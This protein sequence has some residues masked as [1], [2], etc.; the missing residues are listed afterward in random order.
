MKCRVE[1]DSQTNKIL[2]V[3]DLQG[4]P[5]MIYKQLTQ[6]Y[7]PERALK[8]Y[9]LGFTNEYKEF[10]SGLNNY[11]T[12][13]LSSVSNYLEPDIESLRKF[14]K[15]NKLDKPSIPST[16]IETFMNNLSKI[17]SNEVIEEVR[18]DLENKF[19]RPLTSF[20]AMENISQVFGEM[21]LPIDGKAIPV[22]KLIGNI[23]NNPNT[24]KFHK[25]IINYTLDKLN[26][27]SK[28][29]IK[30]VSDLPINE[31]TQAVRTDNVGVFNFDRNE[32]KLFVGPILHTSYD[33]INS[34]RFETTSTI[35]HELYHALFGFK[36]KMY[37]E[38]ETEYLT[39][40]EIY[41]LFELE[42][43]RD[44]LLS[45]YPE[46]KE[47]Y[48]FTDIHELISEAL[49]NA[50]VADLLQGIP[51]QSTKN[52]PTNIYR[53]IIDALKELIS[54]LFGG[55]NTAY[56]AV[57]KE[58]NTLIEEY[59]VDYLTYHTTRD[60]GNLKAPKEAIRVTTEMLYEFNEAIDIGLTEEEA[61]ELIAKYGIDTIPV[62]NKAKGMSSSNVPIY[63][64]G[65]DKYGKNDHRFFFGESY[66]KAK[67]KVRVTENQEPGE[68]T[69]HEG[70]L[71]NLSK[72]DKVA[73]FKAQD[74]II[75]EDGKIVNHG[76]SSFDGI[77]HRL[78][79]ANHGWIVLKNQDHIQGFK[80]ND[81]NDIKE[82]VDKYDLNPLLQNNTNEVLPSGI[83]PGEYYIKGIT[84]VRKPEKATADDIIIESPEFIEF[85]K[86]NPN[87]TLEENLAYYKQC[88]L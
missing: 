22:T 79:L 69:I 17:A 21:D 53:A 26:A 49:S 42:N 85:N 31:K 71:T 43:I 75:P 70:D 78:N 33:N 15:F 37:E 84:L 30:V 16:T 60:T 23:L 5:S 36:I 81:Y 68:Y 41:A 28:T 47:V 10:V 88:K 27:L 13:N 7:N 46:L 2:E 55:N 62:S 77:R 20:E 65:K 11:S 38:N 19:D 8:F 80:S 58:I 6:Q 74:S 72:E 34:L 67:A 66:D 51:Y 54:E 9:M 73:L 3:Y 40:K 86:A 59:T 87:T 76:K 29:T 63:E 14:I 56:N 4:E 32:I 25:E 57:M 45:Q 12:A 39:E 52:K 24:T 83:E 35:L 18:Y 64:L 61:T 50:E 48:A 82:F 1:R 44:T